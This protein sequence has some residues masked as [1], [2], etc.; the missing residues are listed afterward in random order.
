MRQP[1]SPSPLP[2]HV[3][4]LGSDSE[5]TRGHYESKNKSLPVINCAHVKENVVIEQPLIVALLEEDTPESN[6]HGKMSL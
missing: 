6:A 2:H 3:V 4:H 5:N 1:L